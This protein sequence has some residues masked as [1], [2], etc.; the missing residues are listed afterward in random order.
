MSL[1]FNGNDLCLKHI[2]LDADGCIF[3]S[4]ASWSS[5]GKGTPFGYSFFEKHNIEAFFIIQAQNNL[6]WHSS[7]IE[8]IAKITRSRKAISGKKVVLYG[9]SMGGYAACH[10]RNIFQ[11]DMGIAIAPQVFIDK[12]YLSDEKRWALDIEKIQERM[13][14]DEMKNINVQKSELFVFTDFLHD[15]DNA[16][17]SKLLQDR[18]VLNPMTII[19]VPYSNHDVA[20]LLTSTKV[21]QQLLLYI[22][23]NGIF[24][25]S[26]SP[27]CNEL[28]LQDA[29]CF[30][31]YF[32][33]SFLDSTKKDELKERFFMFLSQTQ[34]KDFEALYM[35][36]ECL[37]KLGMH[38]KAIDLIEISITEYETRFSKNAPSYLYLKRDQ[39]YKNSNK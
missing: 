28:Y 11:A 32:R 36:S 27:L 13:L 39:I 24:D 10:F 12:R 6:W 33:N 8:E 7:E 17:I 30:F 25:Y 1:E 34:T 22:N 15:A 19:D 4:F 21:I 2:N 5:T 16:H 29:K 38:N 37:S 35:A 14:F 23:Q 3:I 26:I 9:S 31:N 18:E 20:R